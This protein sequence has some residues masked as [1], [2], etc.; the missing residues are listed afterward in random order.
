MNPQF[1]FLFEA[2]GQLARPIEV[3]KTH[4]GQRRI[5]DI[6]NGS[7]EGPKIK[8][9]MMPGGVDWQYLR[10]DGV[11]VAEARY[12]LK[13]HDEVLIQV[14]SQGLRHGPAEVMQRLV[15]GEEVDP[16]EYYFRVAPVFE[17]PEGKYAWLNKSLFIGYGARYPSAIKLR[18]FQIL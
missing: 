12:V 8:G 14:V 16:A 3:G 9:T 13:T 5:I 1:E 2:S 4:H 10:Q 7:F 11:T 17:A 6:G 15:K 18:I